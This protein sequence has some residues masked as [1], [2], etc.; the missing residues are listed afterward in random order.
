M[1]ELPRLVIDSEPVP[2]I[3]LSAPRRL[4]KI[5]LAA[6]K[7]S[8]QIVT[9]VPGPRGPRGEPGAKGEPGPAF[10]GKAFWYGSGPPG[11][12]IG[13]KA[14]DVYVDIDTGDTYELR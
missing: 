10:S 4:P 13:S 14:G 8:T 12:V 1:T 9:P 3:E 7:A 2:V 5:A 11:A 6:P